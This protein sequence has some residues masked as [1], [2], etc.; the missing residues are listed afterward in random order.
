MRRDK[1]AVEPKQPPPE[2]RRVIVELRATPALI[3]G[4]GRGA[5]GAGYAR[6]EP[7]DVTTL[8]HGMDI[9]IDP[10]Y[11]PTRVPTTL[12]DRKPD[13]D[14]APDLASDDPT[15]RAPQPTFNYVIRAAVT[16][17]QLR[18]LR[19]HPDVIGVFSDPTIHPFITCGYSFPKG[20]HL[21]VERLLCVPKMKS[22]G[23]DGSDV[24]LAI[25]DVGIN[26][27]YLNAHGKGP[28]FDRARSWSPTSAGIPGQW[29]VGHGT[30]CAFDACIAAPRCTLLDIAALRTD[31]EGF[32][33]VL[34]DAVRAYEHLFTVMTAPMGVGESRS[35]VV[36][37]SWGMFDLKTDLPPGDPGN[38]SDNINHPFN[39]SVT[40]LNDAGAD[41]LFAAGNCGIECPDGRCSDVHKT[42]VGA[43]SHPDVLC[44]AGVDITRARVGYS[45]QGPGRLVNRKPDICGYTHFAGSGV[46]KKADTGTSAAC[47][48]VA[49]VVAAFRTRWQYDVNDP[50]TYPASIRQYVTS[51]AGHGLHAHA[52][53]Y[54]RGRG[55]VRGCQLVDHFFYADTPPLR[56]PPSF[57]EEY[58]RLYPELCPHK[59]S[60]GQPGA[61][62][63]P[64]ELIDLLRLAVGEVEEA[65]PAMLEAILAAYLV[66]RSRSG[67]HAPSIA[68]DESG[69]GCAKH[70]ASQ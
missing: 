21:D 25:V 66:G 29:P 28:N 65:D 33:G 41:I 4:S 51:T 31:L 63:L 38:Y 48:V 23:L 13:Y 24:F 52:Y 34:S 20:T 45:S 50:I 58:C 14:P 60:V 70:P 57:M 17:A 61:R 22:Y 37:N 32:A 15:R 19:E 8:L 54:N 59:K 55:V 40:A 3:A 64:V 67:Q 68:D 69:C 2:K 56:L 27:D 16:E 49:G 46:E 47:P 39:R 11:P 53:D 42:I 35:M 44:V 36:S 1:A 26:L 62:S 12:D 10:A 9:D 43:N 30:M 6:K 18:K 5:A 7:F